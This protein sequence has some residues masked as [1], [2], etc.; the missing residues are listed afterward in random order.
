MSTFPRGTHVQLTLTPSQTLTPVELLQ[1]E[2][3]VRIRHDA[4]HVENMLRLTYV[5]E[6]GIFCAILTVFD[7]H[8]LS[9][10]SMNP[11]VR[12]HTRGIR[13]Q[14]AR[15]RVIRALSPSL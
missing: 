9:L 11:S 3:H 15:S 4:F 14:S 7:P 10:F 8:H 1:S 6:N 13:S 12:V 5:S 2:P